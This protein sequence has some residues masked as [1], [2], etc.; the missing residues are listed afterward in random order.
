MKLYFILLL[1]ISSICGSQNSSEKE[2][3]KRVI[4]T[5]LNVKN[6]VQS[7]TDLAWE[8]ISEENDSA[9][10]YVDKA[11][12]FS[13]KNAY[14]LGEAIANET[15]GL[16]HEIVTGN[17]DL[18]SQFY[19]KGIKV[20]EANNLDYA[21]SIYHSLGVMFHTSDSYEKAQ[22]YYT[23]SY[24]LAK[25][26]AD[27]ALIKKCLINLGSVHSSLEDFDKAADYMEKSF[28][29]KI[30]PELDYATYCNL[31]HLYT[32]QEK[33]DNALPY[34]IKAT[35]QHP[36]NPDSEINLYFLLNL[37][38]I[39]KDTTNMKPVLKRAKTAL[40]D[41]VGLRNKSLLL[42]NIADYYKATGNF[43]EAIYYRD[44]YIQIFEEI[45]VKTPFE[46]C[47]L[48]DDEFL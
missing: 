26:F 33:Y 19:F 32:K 3:L 17:Y 36:D 41:V 38:A 37:K 29:I 48:H 10:I 8:Y 40:T 25:K 35:E 1:F 44:E 18:A 6:K 28:D 47:F 11:L 2:R 12:F 5:T 23:K 31:G 13:K 4:D 42:R 22:Q 15:K 24:E 46:D 39:L 43:K 9:L 16:Y 20:C 30:R 27:S 21:S 7:Y 14:P 45:G 34:L